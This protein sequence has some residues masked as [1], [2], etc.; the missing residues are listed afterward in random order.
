MGEGSV[1]TAPADGGGSRRRGDLRPA[2]PSAPFAVALRFDPK[3][4]KTIEPTLAAEAIAAGWFVWID[5]DMRTEGAEAT[6]L[7]FQG[8][9]NGHRS[10]TAL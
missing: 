3:E 6:E 9:Q 5:L 8:A 1:E 4:E 2:G 7:G 10:A